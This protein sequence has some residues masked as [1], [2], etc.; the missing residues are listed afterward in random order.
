MSGQGGMGLFRQPHMGNVVC[1]SCRR[2]IPKLE[3]PMF[4]PRCSAYPT[5]AITSVTIA[6]TRLQSS[7]GDVVGMSWRV[8]VPNRLVTS[9]YA[10]MT[11][12]AGYGSFSKLE[13]VRMVAVKRIIVLAE[14]QRRTPALR[15]A[16]GTF[17]ILRVPFLG[18]AT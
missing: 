13:S 4:K 11:I 3:T 2:Q 18:F 16:C 14:E 12:V 10:K 5:S 17:C 1:G 7:H 9:I 15:T 8:L 6:A